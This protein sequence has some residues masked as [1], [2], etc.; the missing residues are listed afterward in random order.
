VK[1]V[2]GTPNDRGTPARC[3]V[4]QVGFSP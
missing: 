3:A 1:G 4:K 2:H